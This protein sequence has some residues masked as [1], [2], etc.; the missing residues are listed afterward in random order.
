[1]FH[2]VL[3]EEEK[4]FIQKVSKAQVMAVSVIHEFVSRTLQ[5]MVYGNTL[6]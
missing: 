6:F 5:R 1:M 3:D 4:F 2:D